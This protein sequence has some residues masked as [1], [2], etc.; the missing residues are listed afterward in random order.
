MEL[1]HLKLYDLDQGRGT[2]FVRQGKGKKV[3]MIPM[4]VRAVGWIRRYFDEVRP[5]LGTPTRPMSGSL[6]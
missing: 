6:S 5:S 3:R 4:G 1:A 2:V